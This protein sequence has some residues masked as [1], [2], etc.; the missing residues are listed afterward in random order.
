MRKKN[1]SRLLFTW[2]K[3]DDRIRHMDRRDVVLLILATAVVA[4]GRVG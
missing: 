4:G 1:K 3:G 2:E